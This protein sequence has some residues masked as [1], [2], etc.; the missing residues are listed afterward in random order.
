MP[1]R[2]GNRRELNW[3][4]WGYDQQAFHNQFAMLRSYNQRRTIAV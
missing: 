3:K 4:L 1:F 2:I